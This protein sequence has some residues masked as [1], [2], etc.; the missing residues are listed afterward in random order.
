M[1]ELCEFKVQNTLCLNYL[2][3]CP[4]GVSME[5]VPTHY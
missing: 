4:C 5:S 3:K 1:E 2:R